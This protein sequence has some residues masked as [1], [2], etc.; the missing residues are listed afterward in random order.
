MTADAHTYARV[1]AD[2]EALERVTKL[3]DQVEL[4]AER[5]NLM[6]NPTKVFAATLYREGIRLWFQ[7]HPAALAPAYIR[8]SYGYDR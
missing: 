1:R 2:F 8:E 5:L 4:D 6:R 3:T 7:E